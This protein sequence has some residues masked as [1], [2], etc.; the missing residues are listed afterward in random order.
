[1]EKKL[2]LEPGRYYHIYNHAVGSDLLFKS[3]PDYK[4]FLVKYTRYISP[5][6]STL[7]YCLMPN[8]FHT[9]VLINDMEYISTLP[10]KYMTNELIAE[11]LY[12]SFSNLLNSYAQW[13]N[14]KYERKGCL[15]MSNFKR[16]IVE[17]DDSLR[18]LICYIHKNPVESK[19]ADNVDAWN[20]SSYNFI[21]SGKQQDGIQIRRTEII[22]V[23]NDLENFKFLHQPF[24]GTTLQGWY[25]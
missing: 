15:F 22:R 6:A 2:P 4:N 23:Y 3:E 10:S 17:N 14:N 25:P 13:Y 20:Y 19:F 18:R 12:R 8:H 24:E 9:C 7:A 21:T 1:M 5:V 16:K 11:G